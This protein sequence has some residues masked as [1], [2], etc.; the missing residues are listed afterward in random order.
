[1]SAF[2]DSYSTHTAESS[3]PSTRPI[4]PRTRNTT[5][6]DKNNNIS[7]MSDLGNGVN[8]AGSSTA[9]RNIDEPLVKIQPPRREDLQPSYA[10]AIKPDDADADDHGW[11]GAMVN[12]LGSCIGALGA[13][14]CCV[15]CP[16]PYKQVQQ[17][18]VGLITKFGRFTRAVDPGL[19]KVNP[20]SESVIQID[21]KI[22]IVGAYPVSQIQSQ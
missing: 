14:P 19:V 20:L 6:A 22:Q 1:M 11:Y 10:R 4:A 12:T 8:G 13:I 7:T 17:G 9:K 21:V 18:N 3:A 16:N 15:V 2:R 5:V